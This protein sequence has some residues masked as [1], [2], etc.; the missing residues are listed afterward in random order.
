[1]VPDQD[2]EALSQSQSQSQSPRESISESR[3]LLNDEG[4]G[5]R[6]SWTAPSSEWRIASR[7]RAAFHHVRKFKILYILSCFIFIVDFPGLV[8]ETAEL[9]MLQAAVCHDYYRRN[10]SP[11]GPDWRGD[12]P[13]ELCQSPEIQSELAQ[14]R[15]LRQTL[16]FAIGTG[17]FPFSMNIRLNLSRNHTFNTNGHACRHHRSTKSP[18]HVH[19][20][21]LSA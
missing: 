10:Y 2:D 9:A 1:M 16:Y 17:H 7:L 12:I 11:S 8:G 3:P 21:H 18:N 14:L 19:A 5:E 6:S 15:G 4:P 13:E 20:Q